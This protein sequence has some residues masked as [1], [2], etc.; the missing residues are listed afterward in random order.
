M[1]I[2]LL[3]IVI[4]M[5]PMILIKEKPDTSLCVVRPVLFFVG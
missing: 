2:L 5:I 3:T 1:K 4:V